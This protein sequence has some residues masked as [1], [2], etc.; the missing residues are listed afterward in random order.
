[1]EAGKVE[2]AEQEVV[3]RLQANASGSSLFMIGGLPR[4]YTWPGIMHWHYALILQLLTTISSMRTHDPL[5]RPARRLA[6]AAIFVLTCFAVW[7]FM[8]GAA[9]NR[10]GRRL[11]LM[12]YY[13]LQPGDPQVG[14]TER[15]VER[16]YG[17]PGR[18]GM[19]WENGEYTKSWRRNRDDV[20]VI[21]DRSGRVVDYSIVTH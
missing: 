17:G 14:M 5:S 16:L 19:L 2:G 20:S 15:Q 13:L 8:G 7:L 4:L 10:L 18:N 9:E 21:F 3:R 1:M 12:V 6:L 11:E